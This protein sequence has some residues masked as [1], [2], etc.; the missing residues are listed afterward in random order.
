MGFSRQEYWSGLPF[1]PP[2][3]LPHPGME[4][5]PLISLALAGRFFTSSTTWEAEVTLVTREMQIKTTVKYQFTPIRMDT[6]KVNKKRMGMQHNLQVKV[7]VTQSCQILCD[8]V[9]CSPPGSLQP[10]R[11][12]CPWSSP[13]KNTGVGSHSLLQGLFPTQG[14]NLGLPHWA[15][16]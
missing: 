12:L 13:E 6:F 8:S 15:D 1:L 5:L 14:S 11:L 2:G 16:C 4:P 7:L 10:A 3:H 9:D